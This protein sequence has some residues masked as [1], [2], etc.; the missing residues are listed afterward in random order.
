M[1]TIN[2]ELQTS[3]SEE[4]IVSS[5][6]LPNSQTTDAPFDQYVPHFQYQPVR[7]RIVRN[8]EV[9]Y[10]SE[11]TVC[12][13]LVVLHAQYDS[14][15]INTNKIQDEKQ[16][17]ITKKQG[18]ESLDARKFIAS[19]DGTVF[20]LV[21]STHFS[22][23]VGIVNISWPIIGESAALSVSFVIVVSVG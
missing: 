22:V 16:D 21:S 23:T 1:P 12:R 11:R 17:K 19:H 4:D 2:L 8:N 9:E 14:K 13:L 15:D 3:S 7:M 10:I 6:F 20:T 18:L 5:T